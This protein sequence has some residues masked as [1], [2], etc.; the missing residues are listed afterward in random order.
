MPTRYLTKSRFKLGL[1]CPTKLFYTGKSEYVNQRLEDPFL[2]A[3]A[4]GG[5]QVGEL[6]KCYCQGG[7]D[8]KTSDYSE[9]LAQTHE[10][11]KGD[12]VTIFEAAICFKN[13]KR[14]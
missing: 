11:L 9:A 12:N 14:R 4:D 8:I 5:F 7:F 10:L 3:L 2:L 1:E 6:A 13:L